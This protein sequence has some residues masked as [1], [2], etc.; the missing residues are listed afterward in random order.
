MKFIEDDIEILCDKL[1][2]QKLGDTTDNRKAYCI[3]MLKLIEQNQNPKYSV[4]NLHPTKE[5]MLLIK[6]WRTSFIGVCVFA[7]IL[8]LSTLPFID[9]YADEGNRV[10]S[11]EPESNIVL[12]IDNRVSEIT[13]DEYKNLKLG[14]IHF[15]ELRSA[16]IDSKES[17]EGLEHKSYKFNTY[18]WT[19]TKYDGFTVKMSDMSCNEGIDY[20]IIILENG[21][22]I[23]NKN[24]DKADTLTIKAY[25]NNRYEVIVLNTSLNILKYRVKINSYNK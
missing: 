1:V 7:L 19:E 5:R 24:Y 8:V 11:S 20:I 9:V 22:E 18:S 23:F 16:D 14:E 15:N 4:L 13:E 12:N 21:R 17:L 25:Q 10:I 2:I 3:S 6:K